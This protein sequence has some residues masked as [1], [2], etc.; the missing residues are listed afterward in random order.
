MYRAKRKN[1]NR[2]GIL[3]L[4]AAAIALPGCGNPLIKGI[5]DKDAESGTDNSG[6]GGDEGTGG[7]GTGGGTEGG[8]APD[9]TYTVTPDGAAYTATTTKIDFVFSEALSELAAGDITIGGTPGAA[10]PGS[11]SGSG[12]NWSLTLTVSKAGAATV[13]FNKAGIESGAKNITLHKTLDNPSATSIAAKFGI[14][15]TANSAAKVTEVF[16]ALHAYLATNPVETGASTTAHK[17]GAI[18]LGDYIDLAG[19]TVAQY[20]TNPS[21]GSAADNGEINATNVELTDHGWLLRLIVVGINAYSGKNGNGTDP[22][23]VFQFQNVPGKH[24][25][26]PAPDTNVGGYAASE[27]RTYLTGNFLTG[28]TAAGVP[29][30]VLWA[31]KRMVWNGFL[32]GGSSPSTTAD[33][34]EDA[35]FLP[36]EWEM[37]GSKT[38]SHATEMSANQGRLE[39]YEVGNPGNTSRIKYNSGNFVTT[40]WEASPFSASADGF[41]YVNANG[42][43]HGNAASSVGGCAPA[44]CVK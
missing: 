13:A 19:L 43:A 24:R 37:V 5:I 2:L 36:T 33:T 11:L 6:G 23:L 35:L 29:A 15:V 26:N 14:N 8:G 3:M 34:I 21:A 9:I 38:Y 32:P 25:M 44:F 12:T 39:Y 7:G 1:L 27:M 40:Y 10:T 18:A 22:H 30:S 28:L 41:A 42:S 31:P 4:L 20:Y 17:L 16:T